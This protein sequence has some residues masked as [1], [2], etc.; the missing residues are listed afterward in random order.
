LDHK[1]N[2]MPPVFGDR[3]LRPRTS[4]PHPADS[5]AAPPAITGASP[6]VPAGAPPPRIVRGNPVRLAPAA[7]AAIRPEHEQF[8][9]LTENPFGGSTEPRFVYHSASH[10][11]AV[12]ELTEAIRRRVSVVSLTGK[13][14]IGKTTV[15]RSVVEQLGPRTVVSLIGEGAASLEELLGRVL[16]DFGLVSPEESRGE[17]LA[18]TAP[19]VLVSA[20]GDF[21]HSLAALGV[22]ATVIVDDADQV[23]AD[24]LS[25]LAAL[26]E[27]GDASRRVQIVLVGGPAFAAGLRRAS[28]RRIGRHLAARS[29]IGPLTTGE[30]AA[31]VVHRLAVSAP[32]G[33]LEFDDRAFGRLYAATHG[34]PQSINRLCERALQLGYDREAGIVDESIIAAAASDLGMPAHGSALR[35][36]TIVGALASA[37]AGG[38]AAWL[39]LR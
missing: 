11:R 8:Y 27:P 26:V 31:Y 1:K 3:R 30:T 15:C 22:S 12:A 32:N 39:L 37:I 18:R 7:S 9:G 16:V 24:V 33:R 19:D 28:L 23:R 13:P 4:V 2:L 20:I 6:A 34:V 5:P 25:G 38:V 14:G 35:R 36:R 29:T 17:P 21:A 10:D